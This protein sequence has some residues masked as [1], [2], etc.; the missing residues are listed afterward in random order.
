[1]F[2]TVIDKKDSRMANNDLSILARKIRLGKE[3]KSFLACFPAA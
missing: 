3:K 1:L 2:I